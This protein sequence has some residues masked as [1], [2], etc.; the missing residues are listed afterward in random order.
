[1]NIK[2]SRMFL[3]GAVFLFLVAACNPDI[4]EHDSG[5]GNISNPVYG[6]YTQPDNIALGMP[7]YMK[8]AVYE[9]HNHIVLNE[10]QVSGYN[11][12]THNP[13]WVCWHLGPETKTKAFR[14]ETK[15]P[16]EMQTV[17]SDYAVEGINDKY[18]RGHMCPN[19]D[20][21]KGTYT[22]VNIVPQ[23]IHV[24]ANEYRFYEEAMRAYNN[25]K[26]YF[27]AAGP[28]IESDRTFKGKTTG[29]N[30]DVPSFVWRATIIIDEA[31]GDD[32][33]RMNAGKGNPKAYAIWMPNDCDKMDLG[34]SW[35]SYL[36]SIDFIEEKTGLDL[37][38]DLDDRIEAAIEAQNSGS[39]AEKKYR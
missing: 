15:L 39:E 13:N 8:G 9:G 12:I 29:L 20:K 35:E 7:V 33:A 5:A 17:H 19:G 37:F 2:K 3:I 14:T 38:P 11:D 18:N 25:G 21:G 31:P 16:K 6:T 24:N 27:S 10:T 28:S 4:D 34:N 32:L 1:M 26:E 23:D 30:L 22:M 36:V